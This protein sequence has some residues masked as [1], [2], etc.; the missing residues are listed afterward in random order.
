MEE[1]I[2]YGDT[3]SP[4]GD[5]DWF[6]FDA[7][8]G[9]QYQVIGKAIGSDADL[10]LELH[11]YDGTK[12][13][14]SL[15]GVGVGATFT[16]TPTVGGTQYMR[17]VHNMLSYGPNT[18]YTIHYVSVSGDMYEGSND[19]AVNNTVPQIDVNGATQEHDLFPVGDV[20]YVQVWLQGGVTYTA[21][22]E[23]A[24]G[25]AGSEADL[26]LSVVGSFGPSGSIIDF[27]APADGI[28]YFAVTHNS[29]VYDA[30]KTAY[31]LNIIITPEVLDPGVPTQVGM[32]NQS[33]QQGFTALSVAVLFTLFA[34]ATAWGWHHRRQL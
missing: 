27:K 20:D 16:F 28:Y 17:V 19:D 11:T 5:E 22:A 32:N 25:D 18:E 30:T 1:G 3:L 9:V 10:S 26:S 31:R 4:I 15:A 21:S 12:C 2:F 34:T 23:P 24:P 13:N 8:A 33:T 6:T 29:D 7:I 14:G